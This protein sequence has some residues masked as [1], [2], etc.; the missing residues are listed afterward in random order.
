M[1][2]LLPPSTSHRQITAI[3]NA[4]TSG[5]RNKMRTHM[6]PPASTNGLR[7]PHLGLHVLSLVAPMN[8]WI[9]KP[10]MGPAMLRM[11]RY[12]GFAP[13]SRKMGLTAV[14]VSPKLNWTPKNPRF[15]QAMLRAVINGRRSSSAV[16]SP[17]AT[18]MSTD[19]EAPRCENRGSA[20]PSQDPSPSVIQKTRAASCRAGPVLTP[21]QLERGST[22][23]RDRRHPS[24]LGP[25]PVGAIGTGAL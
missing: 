14:W 1:A 16:V 8:G 22:R 7:R 24:K 17:P 21:G 3:H 2:V 18:A 25:W 19:I 20:E 10:V 15:I 23:L 4:V 12:S 11:G 6:A 9:N 5:K 13:S